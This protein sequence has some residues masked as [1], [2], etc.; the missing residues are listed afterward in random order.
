MASAFATGAGNHE[1]GSATAYIAGMGSVLG[2]LMA[3]VRLEDREL[4]AAYLKGVF[5]T[6]IANK[7]SDDAR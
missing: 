5:L 4:A 7:E 1:Q 2:A 3:G 6:A